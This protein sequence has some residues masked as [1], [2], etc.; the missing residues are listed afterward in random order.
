[1]CVNVK[2]T[3][4]IRYAYDILV[5]NPQKRTLAT[6]YE[7][8]WG[9]EEM[10]CEQQSQALDSANGRV[11]FQDENR[12]GRLSRNVGNFA[13]QRCITSQNSADPIRPRSKPE[14]TKGVSSLRVAIPAAK[15]G[16][17]KCF[18]VKTSCA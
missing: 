7:R 17:N 5:S 1:M 18:Q 8:G 10:S 13:N 3:G 11:S 6:Q 14:I 2:S 12:N 16:R 9:T 15:S 4:Y